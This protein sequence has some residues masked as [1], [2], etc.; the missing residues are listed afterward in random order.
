M[1][2]GRR[3]VLLVLLPIKCGWLGFGFSFIVYFRYMKVFPF[4]WSDLVVIVFV[5]S[6][7]QNLARDLTVSM[8]YVVI[9]SN[10]TVSIFGVYIFVQY[11]EQTLI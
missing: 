5:L 3:K 10:C 9:V 1:A 6:L 8:A 4:G 2:V 7:T 11:G